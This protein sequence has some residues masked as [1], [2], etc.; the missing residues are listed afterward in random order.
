MN[1]K[2]EKSAEEL[3]EWRNQNKDKNR[4]LDI[5]KIEYNLSLNSMF[6]R[7][8]PSTMNRLYNGNVMSSMIHGNKLIFDCSYDTWMGPKEIMSCARQITESFTKNRHHDRPF[9]V[10]LYNAHKESKLILQLHKY[11]PTLFEDD[12]PIT[13]SE[14]SY[15]EEFDKDKLCYLTPH[16]RT[17]LTYYNPDMTYIIGA[18]VDKV[19][20]FFFSL[21]FLLVHILL[22]L[23]IRLFCLQFQS[24]GQPMSLAKAKQEGLKM[25][26]LPLELYLDW[27]AS[28]T[29]SLTIDCVMKIMLDL[30]VDANWK[31]AMKHVPTRK[32][33]GYREY[34]KKQSCLAKTKRITISSIN[35]NDN[36]FEEDSQEEKQEVT[37]ELQ[38][39][40]K[41]VTSVN[42][43]EKVKKENEIEKRSKKS[44]LSGYGAEEENENEE[45]TEDW[46]WQ[47][48][49]KIF[50]E[51]ML[52][53][54]EAKEA[55][56]Q[57]VEDSARE[58][59]KK[60]SYNE[61]IKKRQHWND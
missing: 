54:I 36:L 35:L 25:A 27:G 53:R 61:R 59:A 28:S 42:E 44:V 30:Q 9:H 51:N 50:K 13:I 33:K 14:K 32:M 2:K 4:E 40:R 15:L 23:L 22:L 21:L 31:N 11:I 3:L 45:A 56:R 16:C 43:P 38:R 37:N 34:A 58:D 49:K 24:I 60:F 52:K 7:I 20:L 29:K 6:M 1:R 47:L 39:D 19:C 41:E 10:H 55:G 12:Y 48:Q 5:D 46:H 17:D 57:K 26:K 8:Y 18:F